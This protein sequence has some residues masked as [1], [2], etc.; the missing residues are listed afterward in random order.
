M[1]HLF[2]EFFYLILSLFKGV[3]LLQQFHRLHDLPALSALRSALAHP[4]TQLARSLVCRLVQSQVAL[5]D[6]LVLAVATLQ[7]VLPG[8]SLLVGLQVVSQ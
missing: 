5:L 3:S 4:V 7:Q 2:H 8:V 6:G 1:V